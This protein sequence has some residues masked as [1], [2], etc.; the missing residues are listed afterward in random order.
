MMS[1]IWYIPI[2]FT[3]K[4]DRCGPLNILRNLAGA[5][6]DILFEMYAPSYP[7]KCKEPCTF[8]RYQA[9]HKLLFKQI[10]LPSSAP[11]G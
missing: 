3:E 8:V 6:Y 1:L 7:S 5:V 11:A 10:F 2:W 4:P 9:E